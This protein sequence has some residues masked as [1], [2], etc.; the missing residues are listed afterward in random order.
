M[1]ARHSRQPQR[2][3]SGSDLIATPQHAHRD[4]RPMPARQALDPE[5]LT[6]A[7]DRPQICP[8]APAWAAFNDHRRL[9]LQSRPEFPI[10][11]FS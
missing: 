11:L 2:H 6:A 5:R 7:L 8:A 10:S 1:V 3:T 4:Q 9:P